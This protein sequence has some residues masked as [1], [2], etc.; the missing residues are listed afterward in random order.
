MPTRRRLPACPTSTSLPPQ[1]SD[2]PEKVKRRTF[3]ALLASALQPRRSGAAAAGPDLRLWYRRPATKWLEALPLGNGRLGA[4]VFGGVDIE[5]IVLNE[6]TLYS[7]EPASGHLPLDI[8]RD[9]DRV[10]GMIRAGEYLEADEFVKQHWLGRSW[11][12]YQP[13]GDLVLRFEGGGEASDYT[14]ELD[15]GEAVCRVRYRQ[16]DARFEREFFVSQP[17]NV[18]VMR[19]RA[20]RPGALNFRLGF[21]CQHP[22][23][24]AGSG[25]N[26]TLWTG[27]VPGIALRRTLE[28]VEQRNDQ[29]KYPEIWNRDG[30]RKRF[31]RQVLYGVEA[32]GRGARFEVRVLAMAPG[33]TVA[34]GFSG[35]LVKGAR[36]AVIV[37]AAASS[38]YG[39][40]K[41]P[42]DEG[43]NPAVFTRPA[44][45]KAAARS[46]GKLR[47]A[48]VADHRALFDR[49]SLR[50]GEA[51]PAAAL[52]TDERL[53]A[54]ASAPDPSLVA[55]Y[56]QY[57][58]YLLI[59]S[60]RRG[61]QPANLQGIWNV[62]VIPPWGG[63]Y[64]TNINLQMN[65]WA[66][67]TA[68]LAECHEPLF[69]FLREIAVTGARV[70]REMYHR[71]GWVLHH[72]TSLWR[73]AQ[74]VDNEAY[75][76]FW[77]MAGGWLCR[78]LWE[79]HR[80]SP[81]RTF[82][83]AVAYPIMKGAAEFYLSWLADD[84]RGHMVTP[85]S[86]S[87]ENQFYYDG[88]DGKQQM[89]GICMGST[90]DLAVI[91]EL[92]RSVMDAGEVLQVDAEFRA[93]LGAALE[94]LLPYRV[95]SRGQLLE[96]YEEF[97]EAP[98]RHNTSPFYPLFP[99]D[100]FTPRGTPEFAA[101]V[102]K[103]LEERAHRNGGWPGAWD[104]CAWA[105][106]GEG[107]RARAALEGVV[108]RNHPNLF[109]GS[110]GIFQIDGNLG[111]TAAVAEMLV[112]SHAV[113]IELLPALPPEWSSGE[114]KG[115][116]ARGGVT[117][118]LAWREGR[119]TSAR[120]LATV[121]GERRVR[122][123][124]GKTQT[125]QLR[126]ARAVEVLVG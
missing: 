77:P 19:L 44:V 8:T 47:E 72:D 116:R 63:A 49:V 125:V 27:Q 13:L 11:P 50:L 41:S 9:F 22:V 43:V 86:S 94:K 107:A 1:L 112:Q 68:N 7:E 15:L 78:H 111:A 28:W 52:P 126:A 58:R 46:F 26:E 73:G 90:L 39:F 64:T 33:G 5:R 87:P 54:Y 82:L 57:G 14:R 36:E 108:R 69:R 76:S 12:C 66:A 118:D 45:I 83:A 96:Y 109:N 81:D 98:P 67:E 104:A 120:L 10:T 53:A 48:H 16:G 91:R 55:L 123:P 34:S 121:S 37:A 117:V 71:P 113:E 3:N 93:S 89:A 23:K 75:F 85:V 25:P 119:L 92:F 103:L 97:K 17:D 21:E 42:T 62:D 101:A 105:R 51:G 6:D 20:D 30:S 99:G 31:A 80:F 61:T 95:G 38:F 29:W 115:L 74:P 2:I 84:G 59:A 4:M 70:A 24:V 124:D 79:H 114:V 106:L 100:Q 35:I 122:L 18:L 60:S 102:R 32:G 40:D 88:R 110:G 56:F 65:Y